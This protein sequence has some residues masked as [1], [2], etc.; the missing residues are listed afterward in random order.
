MPVIVNEK[1]AVV[2][3][4][5]A[6][7]VRADVVA[8]GGAEARGDARGETGGREGD[9]AREAAVPARIV[10]VVVGRAG[11]EGLVGGEGVRVKLGTCTWSVAVPLAF[12]MP[13]PLP[14]T[15]KVELPAGVVPRVV[16]MVRTEL[17]PGGRGR[18]EGRGRAGGE[19][20]RGQRDGAGEVRAGQPRPCR[21][22]C[23]GGRP[24]TLDGER[25]TATLPALRDG[26]RRGCRRVRDPARACR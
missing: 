16:R 4:R 26:Q 22:R 1:V 25:L 14:V 8:G 5:A 10:C 2:A 21:W 24:S 6:V 7:T 12:A 11:V 13:V 17:V 15:V 18:V 23:P 19:P 20:A 9:R 3:V